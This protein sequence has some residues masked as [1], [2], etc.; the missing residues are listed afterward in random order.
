MDVVGGGHIEDGTECKI[1]G[2]DDHS[3]F[4]V[5][6]GIMTRALSRQV[7]GHLA[8]TLEHYGAREEIVTDIHDRW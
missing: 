8:A 1:L 7:C 6:A 2:I 4:L 5:G 3:R